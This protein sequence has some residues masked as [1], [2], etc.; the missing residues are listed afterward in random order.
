[1]CM[2]T[3]HSVTCLSNGFCICY[4]S[5]SPKKEVFVSV[6]HIITP[7]KIVYFSLFNNFYCSDNVG[8][9]IKAFPFLNIQL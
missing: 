7:S 3:L 2:V 8:T 6:K 5:P 1:M 9:G 4:V